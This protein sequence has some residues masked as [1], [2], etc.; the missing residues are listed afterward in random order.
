[1]KFLRDIARE[2][3]DGGIFAGCIFIMTLTNNGLLDFKVYVVISERLLRSP[4]L[5]T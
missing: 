3:D 1:M 5:L 4:H 2:G